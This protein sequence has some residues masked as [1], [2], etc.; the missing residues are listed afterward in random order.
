[1]PRPQVEHRDAK[2]SRLVAPLLLGILT[3][4]V[5]PRACSVLDRA[6]PS[7]AREQEV[8]VK[9]MAVCRTFGEKETCRDFSY[10]TKQYA[11]GMATVPNPEGRESCYRVM[12]SMS[13]NGWRH[14]TATKDFAVDLGRFRLSCSESSAMLHLTVV[15]RL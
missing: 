14:A 12:N 8:E 13:A 1:M 4:I 15:D 7:T 5:L 9:L 6:G 3:V 10:F 2:G 11:V